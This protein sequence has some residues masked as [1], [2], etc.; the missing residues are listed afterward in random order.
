VGVYEPELRRGHP[1]QDAVGRDPQVARERE[2]EAAADRVARQRGDGRDLAVLQR[3]E[4][5]GEGVR[6]QTLGL[7]G[8]DVV[9]DLADVV[10]RGEHPPGAGQQHHARVADV[11]QHG[12]DRVEDRVVERVAL[13]RV[14]D[15][16]PKDAV[17]RPV[18][19][20]L[21]RHE[22]AGG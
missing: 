15:R 3:P 11:V 18:E 12:R 22:R 14:G 13:R 16:E 9:G 8:E 7:L 5:R 6:D 17:R 21:A 2:L 4:R 20:Q 1:E 10:A 19:E